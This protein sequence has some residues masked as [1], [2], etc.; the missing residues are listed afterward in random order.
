M[1]KK[2][3]FVCEGTVN[4]ETVNTDK[5]NQII[6]P[7][8][9][10][11]MFEGVF[12]I[13]DCAEFEK[14]DQKEDFIATILSMTYNALSHDGDV[15]NNIIIAAVEEGTDILLWGVEVGI[16]DDDNFKYTTLDWKSGGHILKFEDSD[17][18]PIVD[19]EEL[20]QY[21]KDR[22][23]EDSKLTLE[24]IDAVLNLEVDY[25]RSKGIIAD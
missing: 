5:F 3:Y 25:L 17:T 19:Q 8:T 4:G 10:K 11:Q 24:E 23:G 6:D 15:G 14:Y 9:N 22:L 12:Q 18:D 2:I 13:T 1:K 7:K 20:C 21:I 16:I